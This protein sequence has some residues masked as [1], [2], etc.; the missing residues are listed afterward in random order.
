MLAS[1]SCKHG[2]SFLIK[3]S[4]FQLYCIHTLTSLFRAFPLLL[5]AQ[6]P[7]FDPD[8]R[9]CGPVRV[10]L[11]SVRPTWFPLHGS[12]VLMWVWLTD[13]DTEE[14]GHYVVRCQRIL[15]IV[16][17]GTICRLYFLLCQSFR[18][19]SLEDTTVH[20]TCRGGIKRDAYLQQWFLEVAL[21]GRVVFSTV[22]IVVTLLFMTGATSLFRSYCNFFFFQVRSNTVR[23]GKQ[24]IMN[25]ILSLIAVTLC[26]PCFNWA[27]IS[28]LLAVHLAIIAQ[29]YF[30]W[31]M[32]LNTDLM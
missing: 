20:K 10:V 6:Q 5:T 22:F 32:F 30:W 27:E 13:A 24:D 1:Q 2:C 21:C 3:A 15:T 17:R 7:T 16:P 23:W 11:W 8:T 18:R 4:V 31:C 14:V 26:L 12:R 28:V 25:S 19:G 29:F 9:T